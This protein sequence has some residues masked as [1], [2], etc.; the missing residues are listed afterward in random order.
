VYQRFGGTGNWQKSPGD[1]GAVYEAGRKTEQRRI[2]FSAW[3]DIA[4]SYLALGDLVQSLAYV[5]P[6]SDLGDTTFD[7]F[8]FD[9][10]LFSLVQVYRTCSPEPLAE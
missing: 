5:N 2:E 10:Y 1:T 6:A 7:I 3:A 9:E 8:F 4:R